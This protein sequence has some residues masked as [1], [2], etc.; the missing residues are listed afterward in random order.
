M[1]QTRGYQAHLNMCNSPASCESKNRIG[2]KSEKLER[3]LLLKSS[4]RFTAIEDFTQCPEFQIW[5]S[6][7]RWWNLTSSGIILLWLQTYWRTATGKNFSGFYREKTWW[8]MVLIHLQANLY[9]IGI[10]WTGHVTDQT[11]FRGFVP[12]NSPWKKQPRIST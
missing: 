4:W 3:N 11:R 12:Q 1:Q 9:V 6:C 7:I 10:H 2:I 5:M 8:I